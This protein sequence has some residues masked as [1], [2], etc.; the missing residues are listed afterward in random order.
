MS[1]TPLDELEPDT[2]VE[3]KP[4][5]ASSSSSRRKPR[6]ESELQSRLAGCFERIAEA[7]DERG[8]EEMAEI[9]REDGPIMSQGLVS[10]TRPLT[11]L[12]T[13]LL[14]VIAVVEPVL[15]FGRIFRLLALR[16]ADRRARI[17]AEQEQAAAEAQEQAQH[18]QHL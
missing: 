9:I 3:D 6:K 13:P 7:L 8:D 18:E 16:F 11:A 15:A 12:R 1:Q 2:P 14:V 10:L 4:K 5:R 17:M